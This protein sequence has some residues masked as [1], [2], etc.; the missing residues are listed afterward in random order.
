L[1]KTSL[2]I[3][4][5]RRLSQPKSPKSVMSKPM[6]TVDALIVI[7]LEDERSLIPGGIAAAPQQTSIYRIE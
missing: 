7:P 1:G 2:L 4:A 3:V 5:A 6:N